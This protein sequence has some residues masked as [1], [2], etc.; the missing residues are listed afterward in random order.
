MIDF[1]GQASPVG[2]WRLLGGD[3]LCVGLQV[4]M[5]G[6]TVERMVVCGVRGAATGGWVEGEVEVEGPGGSGRPAQDLDAEE[7]GMT[8]DGEG[9]EM[10]DLGRGV[11]RTGGEEDAERDELLD[12]GEREGGGHPLDKFYAGDH[13]LVRLHLRTLLRS[14]YARASRMG[15]AG[16]VADAGRGSEIGRFFPT[17]LVGVNWSGLEGREGGA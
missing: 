8:R 1:V 15:A 16:A 6:L 10:Q 5:M 4:V 13:L 17:R 9:F 12:V 2:R 7:R 3:V 11:G 14:E